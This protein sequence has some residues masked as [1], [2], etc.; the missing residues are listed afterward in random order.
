MR[1]LILYMLLSF[2]AFLFLGCNGC[3]TSNEATQLKMGAFLASN[4][5]DSTYITSHD[6]TFKTTASKTIKVAYSVTYKVDETV[7]TTISHDSTALKEVPITETVITPYNAPTTHDS[8]YMTPVSSTYKTS[9]DSSYYSC[10]RFLWI[11]K[12]CNLKTTK[13]THDT[14]AISLK[15]T[16]RSITHDTTLFKTE[17]DTVDYKTEPYNIFITHD[18]EYVS[19]KWVTETKYKDSTIYVD[20]FYNA[21][22]S[23]DTTVKVIIVVPPPTDT[24][25]TEFGAKLQGKVAEQIAA[26]QSLNAQWTRTGIIVSMFNGA[27]KGLETYFDNGLKVALNL[28]YNATKPAPFFTDLVVYEKRIRDI[29]VKYGARLKETGSIVLC[30]NE[31]SNDGYYGNAPISD[32]LNLLRVLVKVAHEYGVKVSD[33]CTFIEYLSLMQQGSWPSRLDDKIKE[34]REIIA[35]LKEIDVDYLNVHLAIQNDELLDGMIKN[36]CDYLR[37]ETGKNN[38]ITNE[39]HYENCTAIIVPKTISEWK[40][41]GVIVC[42]TWSGDGAASGGNSPADALSIGTTLTSLGI[43]QRDAV[44]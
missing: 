17:L 41:A 7:Y 44:K 20:S 5:K 36:S 29:F 31:P 39:Y 27:D 35:G 18:S 43:A 3:G 9:H 19:T 13:T 25:K 11:F 15:P 22:T 10:W 34:Q 12:G 16:I 4:T 40:K 23:H 26:L 1:K 2:A 24:I 37:T 30:E 32:Y 42:V 33:G 14:T 8:T 38:V 6:S 21:I 28:T